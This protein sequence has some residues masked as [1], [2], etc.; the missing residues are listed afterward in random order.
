[1]AKSERCLLVHGHFYQ[2]PRENPWTGQI[3]PQPSAAP[4]DNW[5]QRIADECYLPMARSR[6]VNA[7]GWITDLYNNYAHVSFNFGPTLL[8]WLEDRHPD[9]ISHLRDAV[10]LAPDFAVAQAYNHMILPLSDARDRHTQIVWGMEE[11][12]ARFGFRPEGMWLPECAVDPET[13]RSLIDHGIR[14]VILSP[15][16]ASR[17]RPFGENAWLDVSM[18]RIDTRRAYRLFD[19]DGAGRTHFERYLNVIF[20]SPGLNLKVSFDH[21]LSRPA[22]LAKELASCYQPDCREA[23]LVSIVTDGEIYGHHERNG[24]DA[25]ARLFQEIAPAIGVDIV[26]AGG[27]IRAHPPAWEVKLWNGE[28]EKG[29]SWSCEHGVGRWFRHCGCRPST[30]PHRSQEWRGPL[31]EAFD[32]LRTEVRKTVRRELGG[33]VFDVDEARED[34]LQVT[35]DPGL[36]SRARFLRRHSRKRLSPLE[37]NRVWRLLEASKNAMLM[38]ASCGWFFDEI[39]GLEPVQ[40]MRYAL[41]AAELSQPWC[42]TDLENLLETELARAASNIPDYRDGGRVFRQFAITSRYADAELAAGVA[43]CLAA[44]F[45]RDCLSWQL[46]PASRFVLD[47]EAAKGVLVCRDPI[48]DR[49]ITASWSAVL[50]DWDRAG[51]VVELSGFAEQPGDPYRERDEVRPAGDGASPAGDVPENVRRVEYSRLP[52]AVR[53]MLYRKNALAGETGL[54]ADVAGVG[55]RAKPFLARARNGKM[56]APASLEAA[57]LAA[58]ELEL[59]GISHAAI[60]G[61]SF[62]GAVSDSIKNLIERARELRLTLDR[63]SRA[64]E[65]Y[66]TAL[67]LLTWLDCSGKPGWLSSISPRILADA[68]TWIAPISEPC[69]A[70][71]YP[72]AN[73]FSLALGKGLAGLRDKLLAG[74]DG[75]EAAIPLLAPLPE[76]LSCAGGAGFDLSGFPLLRA[77]FWD[78]LEHALPELAGGLNREAASRLRR[79]GLELGFAAET[80]DGRLAGTGAIQ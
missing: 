62:T 18:G 37:A 41:R 14:F 2:P 9:A 32:R 57:V 24:C 52:A 72:E 13:V 34:Y 40:N 15:H 28:D 47:G 8:A 58:L 64:R 27:Y 29:T 63:E 44:G 42:E 71:A 45:P 39:S 55:I 19:I 46:L 30:S 67:E 65:F 3:E 5:N 23:Q 38:Y 1:M 48:L 51:G 74:G 36:A 59:D 76:L 17:T 78:F 16:Q 21:I 73:C 4:W 12:Q 43:V 68:S 25:L 33:L 56:A 75:P 35:L 49:F 80:M 31:R 77:K 66:C 20:Y 10:K 22:D 26:S 61:M 69:L 6:I 11:F 70:I 54:A 7:D 79:I 50:A 53:L 60:S